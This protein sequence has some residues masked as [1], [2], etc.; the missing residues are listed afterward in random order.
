LEQGLKLPVNDN[1]IHSIGEI[2]E[3]LLQTSYLHQII[4]TTG[5]Q[6]GYFADDVCSADIVIKRINTYDW[7]KILVDLNVINGQLFKEWVDK[8]N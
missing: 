1:T 3:I 6:R 8:P 2:F 5:K 7:E 4:E